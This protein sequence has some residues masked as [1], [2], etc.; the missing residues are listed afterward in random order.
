MSDTI[1]T[2]GGTPSN[3]LPCWGL[4]RSGCALSDKDIGALKALLQI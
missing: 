4:V 1:A 2:P 3:L